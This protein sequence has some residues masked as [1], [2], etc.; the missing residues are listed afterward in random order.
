M[1][2][3]KIVPLSE[4]YARQ[5]RSSRRDAFSHEIVEQIATGLGPCRVSLQPFQPGKDIRILFSHSPFDIDNAYNQSGPVFIQKEEVEAYKDVHVFPPAIKANKES[6]PITLIG[7]NSSQMM[8]L[9]ELVGDRDIDEL[10]TEIFSI[11]SDVDFLHARNSK[12]ACFIC[13]IERV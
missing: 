10:I 12:A 11:H 8:V 5:I 6:F 2:T 3:F 7:Y 9:T 1:K 13:K 4:E